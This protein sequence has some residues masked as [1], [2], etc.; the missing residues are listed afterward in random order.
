M[1]NKPPLFYLRLSLSLLVC[2]NL[3]CSK[4]ENHDLMA[5]E[6]P[7]APGDPMRLVDLAE[8]VRL[9]QLETRKASLLNMVQGVQLFD[10][11]LYVVDLAGQLLVFDME[12]N[13]LHMLGKSGNGPGEYTY[14]SS[15]AIDG[16]SRLIYIASGRKLL[17]YS[18]DNEFV[19]EAQLPFF[20]DYL[21]AQGG[22]LL[23]LAQLD[24]METEGGYVNQTTLLEISPALE[25]TD[26]IPMRRLTL[27][28]Q[29]AASFPYKH[30]ITHVD[31]DR[32]LY[33][34]VLTNEPILRDTLYRL[35]AK[36]LTPFAKLDFKK[37]TLDE[38]GIKIIRIKNMVNSRGYLMC[39]YDSDGDNMLFLF[40]KGKSTGHNLKGGLLDGTGD[41]V[42]LRP[43][44]PSRDIFYFIKT[45]TFSAGDTEEPNPVI[46]IVELK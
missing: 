9:V 12:G 1:K 43:L 14:I 32:Y 10:E 21:S 20:I 42:L 11:K 28:E 46:G 16:S 38:K 5:I 31:N 15:L 7:A 19:A 35:D 37:K 24:G 36:T 18:P 4:D 30:F 22:K 27:K 6:V 8:S 33:S 25:V 34:P 39:E 3:G 23:A 2:L 13:F 26:S 45:A 41:P 44:N 17:A 29:T 40:D